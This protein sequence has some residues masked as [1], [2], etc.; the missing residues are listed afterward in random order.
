MGGSFFFGV[1]AMAGKFDGT[2]VE[3]DASTTHTR[4]YKGTTSFSTYALGNVW[5]FK[6]V[7]LGAEWVGFSQNVSNKVESTGDAGVDRSAS[8]KDYEDALKI[9]TTA[10]GISVV[11]V[12]LGLSL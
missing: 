4:S 11:M 7:M 3:R 10:G 6:N 1:G 9:L 8:D 12:H 2:Y 5:E